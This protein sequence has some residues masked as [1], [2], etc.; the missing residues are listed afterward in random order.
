MAGR[1]RIR[2]VAGV[3]GRVE[4][5]SIV[6]KDNKFIAPL[7]CGEC[8]GNAHLTRRCPH[9]VDNLEARVF[10]CHECGHQTERVVK[11]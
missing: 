7:R 5:H 2:A 3:G 8:G 6:V 10:E 9:P 4:K 1:L 11:A